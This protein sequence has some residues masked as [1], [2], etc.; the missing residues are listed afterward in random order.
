MM[1]IWSLHII[2][3]VKYIQPLNSVKLSL[4]TWDEMR[5]DEMKGWS[6][7]GGLIKEKWVENDCFGLTHV[8]ASAWFVMLYYPIFLGL[9]FRWGWGN[10]RWLAHYNGCGKLLVEAPIGGIWVE[11]LLS[12]LLCAHLVVQNHVNFVCDGCPFCVYFLSFCVI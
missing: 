6:S 2:F 12:T 1:S 3:W 7:Q 5:W 11:M 4:N 10:T 9:G 8:V